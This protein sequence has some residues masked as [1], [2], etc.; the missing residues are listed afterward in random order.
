MTTAAA[1][2]DALVQA[3][4]SLL[5][6][7]QQSDTNPAVLVL[8]CIGYKVGDVM[9]ATVQTPDCC[10][11]L[12]LA[13]LLSVIRAMEEREQCPETLVHLKSVDI[14]L[15]QAIRLKLAMPSLTQPLH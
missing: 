11:A 15:E 4:T 7:N 10:S 2:Y 3:S 12:P 13:M 9:S 8:S 14:A 6:A 1:T 5:K